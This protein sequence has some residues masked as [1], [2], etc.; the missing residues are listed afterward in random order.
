MSPSETRPSESRTWP[1]EAP[2]AGPGQADAAE[3]RVAA[4]EGAATPA[5]RPSLLTA[6]LRA[7]GA[8]A[9]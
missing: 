6:L 1:A 5:S 3:E 4:E 2:H 7:L 9:T 8:W